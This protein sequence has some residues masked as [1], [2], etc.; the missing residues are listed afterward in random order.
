VGQR[1]DEA[2]QVATLSNIGAEPWRKRLGI[3]AYQVGE[4]ARYAQ[5]SAKTVVAWHKI[6]QKVLL[7][8]VTGNA[9]PIFSSLN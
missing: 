4:A 7:K 1:I 6:D 9:F 2:E 5:I 8:S 3:P